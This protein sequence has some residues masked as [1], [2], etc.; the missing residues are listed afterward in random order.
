[1]VSKFEVVTILE[2][3]VNSNLNS[4]S[5]FLYISINL[6]ATHKLPKNMSIYQI[7]ICQIKS[8]ILFRSQ[9]Y[10]SLLLTTSHKIDIH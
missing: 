2:I 9:Y 10:L 3:L 1:M 6:I 7:T 4:K 8:K 5:R